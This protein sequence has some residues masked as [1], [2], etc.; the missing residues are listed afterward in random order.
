M[1]VEPIRRVKDVRAIKKMLSNMP[2]EY[3]LFVIGINT[4]LRASDILRLMR[5]QL[6]NVRPGDEIEIIEKKTRKRRRLTLNGEVVD[7]VQKLLESTKDKYND[8]MSLFQGQRGPMTVKTVTRLVK[9][10]C[11]EINL[12]GNFGSHTMRKTFGFHQR[13]RLNTSVPELMVLYNHS[14]QR[15]TLDYLCVQAEEIHEAYMKLTY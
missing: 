10:W 15:Q 3:C 8:E 6:R 4:N 12:E 5:G 7:A 2:R 1:K 11:A 13:T 14:T 9:S